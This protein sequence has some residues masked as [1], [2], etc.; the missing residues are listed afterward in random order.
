MLY[1]IKVLR[2]DLV[3]RFPETFEGQELMPNK[4]EEVKYYEGYNIFQ[5]D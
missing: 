3:N 5:N 1:P 4:C 2:L